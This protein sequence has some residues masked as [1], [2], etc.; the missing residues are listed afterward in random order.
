[1]VELFDERVDGFFDIAVV[2]EVALGRIEFSFDVNVEAERMAVQP[3]ALVID[4][5]SRQVVRGFK[6]E[7]FRQTYDHRNTPGRESL[8][9]TGGK[10]VG[11]ISGIESRA[12]WSLLPC[13]H[14][15]RLG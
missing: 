11:Q 10:I 4:G 14:G 12:I 15:R 3:P 6:V 5:E 13:N 9:I 1:M 7:R 2:D 8:R